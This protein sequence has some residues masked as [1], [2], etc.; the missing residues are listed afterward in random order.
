MKFGNE[1][2]VLDLFLGFIK[3]KNEKEEIIKCES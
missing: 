3:N 2:S 1:E